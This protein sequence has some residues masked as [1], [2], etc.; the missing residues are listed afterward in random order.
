MW[1][2]R[3]AMA[4]V[5]ARDAAGLEVLYDRYSTMVYSL[6]LRIV[7]RRFEMRNRAAHRRGRFRQVRIN[8]ASH[9]G[10]HGRAERG[11]L[12]ECGPLDG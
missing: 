10:Q 3:E 4:R 11:G 8:S 5:A 9:R 2:D 6:A 1:D 12:D 7:H